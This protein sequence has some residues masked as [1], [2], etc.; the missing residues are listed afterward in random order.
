[1]SG[2]R[3]PRLEDL[4]AGLAAGDRATLGRALTLVESDLPSDRDLAQAL[5]AQVHAR[6]GGARRVGLTG[7]PGAGKSTMIDALGTRLT[8]AGRRVAVLAVDPTSDRSGGSILGDKTRMARLSR[9]RAAFVRPSPSRGALGG[10]GRKTRESILIVEAAG[11]DVVL[12]ETVGVG[13]S[14]IA[15]A[16]MVDCF[17]V[18]MLPNAGDELQGIKRGLLEMA[19][20]LAVNKADGDLIPAAELARRQYESAL[21]LFRPARPEWRP[22][23]L[24]V[25]ARTEAGIDE[26]WAAI[27]A[28][29][30]ALAASGGLAE[31]RA[32]QAAR[33]MWQAVEDELLARVRRDVSVRT[34]AEALERDVR[35]GLVPATAAASRILERV[36][37]HPEGEAPVP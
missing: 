30:E 16:N 12:V 17:V 2:R 8:A 26:L 7:V 32:D 36:G 24:C 31:V 27:E 13:Q 19:D 10:V 11:Y 1:M 29:R 23:T 20:I 6:T 4:E 35:G 9:D 22:R 5:L 37:I 28:H 25:S 3:R 18:L 21:T 33:W 34:Y 14:E 15:V